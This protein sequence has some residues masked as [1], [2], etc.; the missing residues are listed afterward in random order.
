MGKGCAPSVEGQVMGVSQEGD[1]CRVK[2]LAISDPH[3]TGAFTTHGC[4][5]FI[6]V[7]ALIASFGGPERTPKQE[8]LFLGLVL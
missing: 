3:S 5:S 1:S 4:V 2:T 8:V 6:S 7:N